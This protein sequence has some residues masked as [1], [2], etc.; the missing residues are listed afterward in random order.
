VLTFAFMLAYKVEN[1]LLDRRCSCHVNLHVI[2]SVIWGAAWG[3]LWM[4]LRILGTNFFS[5]KL[6]LD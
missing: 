2:R 5:C 1:K 4:P 6:Y 3:G